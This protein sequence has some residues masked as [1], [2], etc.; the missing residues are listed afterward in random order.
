MNTTTTD[1]RDLSS[2]TLPQGALPAEKEEEISLL[3]I[4][5]VLAHRKWLIL[6]FAVGFGLIGLVVSL[7]MPK[8]YMA[9]TTVLPPQQNSSLSSA[10]MSQI[11]NLGPLG[12]L[13]GS[14]MGLKNPN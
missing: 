14:S 5:I 2:E 1:I 4:L 9:M 6:K 12:A 8:Q 3:D 7:I 10:I 11:G 13:A